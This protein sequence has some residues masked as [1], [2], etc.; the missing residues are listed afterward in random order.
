MAS[1]ERRTEQQAIIHL[2]KLFG[3]AILE[4]ILTLL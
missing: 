4:K 3:L 2:N 1:L